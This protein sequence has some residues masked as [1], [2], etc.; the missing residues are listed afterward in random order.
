MPTLLLA[1]ASGSVVQTSSH[2]EALVAQSDHHRS[3]GGASH[4]LALSGKSPEPK[5]YVLVS[6]GGTATHAFLEAECKLKQTAVHWRDECG[7]IDEDKHHTHAVLT[8]TYSLVK[9]CVEKDSDKCDAAT[10]ATHMK[11]AYDDVF[12]NQT[13]N[14]NDSPYPNAAKYV[15]ESPYLKG[16]HVEFLFSW[17]DPVEWAEERNWRTDPLCKLDVPNPLDLLSCA[18]SCKGSLHDC[19]VTE[20]DLYAKKT[21]ADTFDKGQKATMKVFEKTGRFK[22]FRLFEQVKNAT[23]AEKRKID[24]ADI[25]AASLSEERRA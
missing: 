24:F 23:R 21:L 2:P 17:R 16:D 1:V 18:E 8:G 5:R 14:L 19:L 3:P 13:Y 4:H 11:A 6:Q 9:K 25:I 20:K 10:W 7:D 22:V 15:A 12:A